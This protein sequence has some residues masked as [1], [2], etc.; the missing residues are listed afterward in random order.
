M[1]NWR[2]WLDLTSTRLASILIA[3]LLLQILVSAIVP[4]QAAE[5]LPLG[6]ADEAGRGWHGIRTSPGFLITLGL[7]ALNLTAGNIKRFRTVLRVEGTL[8]RARHV[9]SIL[10]HLALLMVIVGVTLNSLY[11]FDGV[12]GLTEGQTV[13]DVPEAYFRIF[14][15][16][17]YRPEP[18]R[19]ALTLESLERQYA[20][21]D[22]EAEAALVLVEA[23]EGG[24]VVSGAVHTNHSLRWRDLEFHFGSMTG[25]SPELVVAD[26][27]GREIFHSFVRL[28]S[29][30]EGDRRLGEDFVLIS[31]DNL[32]IDLSVEESASPACRLKVTQGTTD[33]FAGLVGPDDVAEAGQYVITVPRLR[34]WC[35]VHSIA[36][37]WLSVVFTGFWLALAGLAVRA[38]AQAGFGKGARG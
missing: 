1:R 17:M 35:Y 22:A 30:E 3:L 16:P 24:S 7:L 29:R 4:Q 37:P 11:R 9:G 31:G 12:F 21:G 32:R 18:E 27:S 25:Y 13:R 15:G 33:L 23:Q 34:S 19:F 38:V 26:G 10:F 20:V 36:N 28:K 14:A 8:L 6:G 2:A 5:G